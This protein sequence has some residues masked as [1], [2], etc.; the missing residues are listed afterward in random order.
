MS[1]NVLL[2]STEYFKANTSVNHEVDADIIEP[3]I[4]MSADKYILPILGSALYNTILD[5]VRAGTITGSYSALTATYIQP[6]LAHW[7]LYEVLPFL[8]FRVTNINLGKKSNDTTEA[9]S[10][11]EVNFVCRRCFDTAGFYSERL[12]RY[13]R[14]NESTFP[15]FSNPGQGADT[16]A[17]VPTSYFSGIHI[18]YGFGGGSFG[19][20]AASLTQ[21]R[22]YMSGLASRTPWSF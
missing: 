20:D 5:Q 19:A 21:L 15:E 11:E 13:L 1:S 2:I 3:A 8:N 12:T 10:I 6:A 22:A 16:I 9:S 17:P 7:T 4:L 14:A 18:P